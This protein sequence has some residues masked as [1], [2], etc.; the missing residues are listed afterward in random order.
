MFAYIESSSFE[1]KLLM[2][3]LFS[4]GNDQRTLAKKYYRNTNIET[5][6]ITCK[7]IDFPYRMNGDHRRVTLERSKIRVSL[8]EEK[9]KLFNLI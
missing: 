2:S 1:S 8:I 4:E 6:L 7:D 5:K 9:L 3:G